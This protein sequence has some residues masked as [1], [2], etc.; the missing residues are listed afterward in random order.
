MEG[1]YIYY[2]DGCYIVFIQ[3]CTNIEILSANFFKNN[4]FNIWLLF[5]KMKIHGVFIHWKMYM[6]RDIEHLK[7]KVA[8]GSRNKN[9]KE[10]K[11]K[12]D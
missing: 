5:P 11:Y 12:N 6:F 9:Y 10:K 2:V 3:K 4:N 1:E 7:F 8:L